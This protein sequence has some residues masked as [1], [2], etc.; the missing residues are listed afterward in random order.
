MPVL[1][2]PRHTKE[3]LSAGCFHFEAMTANFEGSFSTLQKTSCIYKSHSLSAHFFILILFL[4]NSDTFFKI[5]T[6]NGC[7]SSKFKEYKKHSEENFHKLLPSV[8][9]LAYTCSN[10]PMPPL[11]T[12]SMNEPKDNFFIH[13]LDQR[14]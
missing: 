9:L 6:V 10:K 1:H 11:F 14:Y 5:F 8:Y 13:T 3:A 12:I 4:R 7:P 2:H